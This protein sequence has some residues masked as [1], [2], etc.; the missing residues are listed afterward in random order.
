MSGNYEADF[1]AWANEQVA[2]LRAGNLSAADIDHIADE[3]ESIGR[4]EKRELVRCLTVLLLHLL[5]WQFQPSRRGA[6]WRASI[7]NTRDEL[8]DHMKDN[9]SLKS[10]LPEAI[11]T[12][13]LRGRR[14][15]AAETG[16]S[17]DAFPTACP[18]SFEQIMDP[19]FWPE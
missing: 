2:L 3:I 16:L 18:W 13:F 8:E 12:A 14:T 19:D 17:Q 1:Y 7:E 10:K 4:R 15:A 6:S 9:P 11:A 5:K